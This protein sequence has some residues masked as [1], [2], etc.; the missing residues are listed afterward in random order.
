LNGNLEF[1]AFAHSSIL[2]N[3]SI[4]NFNKKRPYETAF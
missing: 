4:Y 1:F 2:T 3:S